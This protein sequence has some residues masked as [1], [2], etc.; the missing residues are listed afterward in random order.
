MKK[1]EI[2][3]IQDLCDYVGNIQRLAADLNVHQYTVERWRRTGIPAKYHGL[4]VTLYDI[5]PIE[6]V[7]INKKIVGA[8]L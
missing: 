6:I 5:K 7:S 2:K 1:T 8:R 4:L 3:T